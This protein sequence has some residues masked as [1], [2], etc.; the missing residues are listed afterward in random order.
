MEKKMARKAV[1]LH[2]VLRGF[3]GVLR[4]FKGF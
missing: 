4:G 3:K 2:R 1:I